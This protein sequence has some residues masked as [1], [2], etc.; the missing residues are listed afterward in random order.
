MEP[1]AFEP[2]FGPASAAVLQVDQSSALE[3][4]LEPFDMDWARID[5]QAGQSY[6]FYV[7]AKPGLESVPV[8]MT[9][10]EWTD[11]VV[12]PLPLTYWTGFPY[13]GVTS[14]N[15]TATENGTVYLEIEAENFS[16]T[17]SYW[18]AAYTNQP[19][20]MDS[21]ESDDSSPF[22]GPFFVAGD[23]PLQRS[24]DLADL[25]RVTVVDAGPGEYE[26]S[27][28]FSSLG[29]PPDT[30]IE[31]WDSTGTT[32]LASNDD[33]PDG[34]PLSRVVRLTAG[35]DPVIWRV[36]ITSA[37]GSSMGAYT[38]SAEKVPPTQGRVWGTVTDPDGAVA[39]NALVELLDVDRS[40]LRTTRT[41]S[42]GKFEF[43]EVPYGE[44]V[45]VR[46]Q[47]EGAGLISAEGF[48]DRGVTNPDPANYPALGPDTPEMGFNLQVRL[49]WVSG[50]VTEDKSPFS[51]LPGLN[52]TVYDLAGNAI[53][54]G[55]T[56]TYGTYRVDL[57]AFTEGQCKV[58]ITD[59]TGIRRTTWWWNSPDALSAQSASIPTFGGL[60]VYVPLAPPSTH[61]VSFDLGHVR[62][63]F[64]EVVTPGGVTAT[65]GEPQ[66]LP[67]P[68][69]RMV[70]GRYFDIHPTLVHA[71]EATVTISIPA[72][73]AANAAGMRLYHWEGGAWRDITTGV[74]ASGMTVTG[75]TATFSDFSLQAATAELEADASTPWIELGVLA[76]VGIALVLH[77]R[78][79]V[80]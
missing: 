78:R 10:M 55:T 42:D 53:G 24:L 73:E 3:R 20:F 2:D 60:S 70:P 54:T 44:P 30:L 64:D 34:G 38:V 47:I 27:T 32:L 40:V 80:G 7:I 57:P 28:G 36:R 56:G 23:L 25:D 69:F 72:D 31:V 71:G 58:K 66:H 5:V 63:A 17:G 43:T 14:L 46:A 11:D 6:D 52:V 79:S 67:V 68:G 61:D 62:V 65:P 26:I 50:W 1:D 12:T 13:P 37:K 15:Y 59:P 39:T 49:P 51:G 45:Q 77:R 22:G 76:F 48:D 75:R 41:A 29:P 9:L 8:R 35:Y 74:D 19:W 33:G 18:L 16:D 4:T 21:Y